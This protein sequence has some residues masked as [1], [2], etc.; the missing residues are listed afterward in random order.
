MHKIQ[1][2]RGFGFIL[3]ALGV[4][5]VLGILSLVNNLS[6]LILTRRAVAK[7]LRAEGFYSSEMTAWNSYFN[8]RAGKSLDG[9][10]DAKG[11]LLAAFDVR[12]DSN[13]P[14]TMTK[15]P[16]TPDTYKEGEWL[17]LLTTLDF[18]PDRN[19]IAHYHAEMLRVK[20]RD[21][22]GSY[23]G[24]SVT[25]SKNATSKTCLST[26]K[27]APPPLPSGPRRLVVLDRTAC[28]LLENGSV[29]CWGNGSITK[30]SG[31]SQFFYA[32]IEELPATPGFTK[33]FGRGAT[34]CGIFDGAIK[35]WGNSGLF[36]DGVRSSDKPTPIAGLESGVSELALHSPIVASDPEGGVALKG[37]GPYA[38]AILSDGRVKCWGGGR[39]Y[40]ANGT[41]GDNRNENQQDQITPVLLPDF[42]GIANSVS[43]AN[44]TAC[45]AADTGVYCW[46]G[47]APGA[48]YTKLYAVSGISS[49]ATAIAVGISHACVVVNGSVK[50][51]G[52][53]DHGQLGL[54]PATVSY[55][56]EALD[57]PG[58]SDVT[59][60]W[61]VTSTPSTCALRKGALWCWPGKDGTFAPTRVPNLP[62]NIVEAALGINVFCA[63]T[64]DKKI[65]CWKAPYPGYLGIG[66]DG[67]MSYD[68]YIR[69]Y[70]VED[71]ERF[72]EFLPEGKDFSDLKQVTQISAGGVSTCA[73]L[74]EKVRCW[75]TGRVSD[76][77][78]PGG[79]RNTLTP[80]LSDLSQVTSV[81][82]GYSHTCAVENGSVKCWGENGS[83]QL[84]AGELG[85]P[86]AVPLSVQGIFDATEVSA[87]KADFTCAIIKGALKCWG[88]NSHGQ[89][90]N[91]SKINSM[92]PVAV[93]GL[94]SGVS[95]VALGATHSCAVVSGRAVCWGKGPLGVNTGDSLVPV[96]VQGLDSGV[97]H[98]AAGENHTCAIHNG[99]AKCWGNV[100]QLGNQN[101]LNEI[102]RSD[103]IPVDGLTSNVKLITAGWGHTCA[104]HGEVLKCWGNGN[105]GELGANELLGPLAVSVSFLPKNVSSIAAYHHTCAVADTKAF[106]WGQSSGDTHPHFHSGLVGHPLDTK[107]LIPHFY[108]PILVPII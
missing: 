34:V 64:A 93:E 89:L 107:L 33:F 31:N 11:R 66:G 84:G 82:S 27:A 54:D 39:G 53:N 45:V 77:A 42:M 7:R 106:C 92:I 104:L 3:I 12:Y 17:N 35:C 103:P 102:S 22:A 91:N 65:F 100:K 21:L 4:L 79:F 58:L 63:A 87:A 51:W 6:T 86:S 52:N 43:L 90:G 75:G 57:V 99:A 78:A 40:K 28:F 44:F 13:Q 95:A 85:K 19:I 36:A 97:T 56:D 72:K 8:D 47:R 1:G 49:G 18:D 50:C 29:K 48:G 81:S 80:Q 108:V 37:R 74:E 98:I 55:T 69:V 30:D 26:P 32:P 71:S 88:Q 24:Y 62:P 83:G 46:G 96:Q 10:K 76:I 5:S 20:A 68:P 70:S 60:I 2:N 105:S 9:A 61:A 94:T 67:G 15:E 23:C 73:L 41:Y 59:G 101:V 14:A 16:Y 25:V 38:C